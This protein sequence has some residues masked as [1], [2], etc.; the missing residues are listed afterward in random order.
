MLKKYTKIFEKNIEDSLSLLW[1]GLFVIIALLYLL[2]NSLAVYDA[3]GQ[4]NLVWY[5]K[6]YLWPQL[7]GWNPFSLLGFEQGLAYPSLFHYVAATL[8]FVIGINWSVLVLILS[9]ILVLPLSI[10]YFTGIFTTDRE[11]KLLVASTIAFLVVILPGY[12]GANLKALTQV[13]LV[14]SWISLPLVFFYLGSLPR[15]DKGRVWLPTLLATSLILTHLVAGLV[16]GVVWVSLLI[17][18]ALNRTISKY[19]LFHLGF[20]AAITS[21]F[22]LP[23]LLN[24][25]S[26]STSAH[27]SSLS[28][29]NLFVLVISLILLTYFLKQA[30]SLLS[31]LALTSVILSSLTLADNL[32][33]NFLTSGF[34]WEKV[35]NLH[36]YRFQVY[37]Y[38]L[39]ASLLVCFLNLKLISRK[40]VV[41]AIVVATLLVAVGALVLKTPFVRGTTVEISNPSSGGRFLETFS[42]A[43]VFPL[44]YNSQTTLIAEKNL[45]WAYGLFT[46]AT[47]NGPYL[48]S[49]IKSLNKTTTYPARNLVENQVVS[50]SKTKQALSLFG[51]SN[52]LTIGTGTNPLAVLFTRSGKKSLVLE[53]VAPTSLVE[54]MPWAIKP[55]TK[56]WNQQVEKWWQSQKS[57]NEVLVFDPLGQLKKAPAATGMVKI[58]GYNATWTDFSLNVDGQKDLPVLVK[59]GYSPNWQASSMGRRLKIYQV[60]P[61]LMLFYGSGDIKFHYQTSLV[62]WLLLILSLVSLGYL[63]IWQR[64]TTVV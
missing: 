18:A 40:K 2:H 58:T 59:F 33:E 47:P 55:V 48:S 62:R 9:S 24:Y 52:L 26:L 28:W 15:I 1:I 25:G 14:T 42:R 51:I 23:F 46:D 30:S 50:A 45:P 21:F 29:P 3:P 64:K 44:L 20:V 34:L 10:F 11:K 39:A 53:A 54:V 6:N 49:L 61:S 56:D 27:L 43:E 38:Y 36:L 19:L 63:F 31:T 32:I 37:S 8:S 22:W 17:V 12:L 5:L 7:W 35:Y 13:G 41:F 4:V 16:V 57:E 60:S